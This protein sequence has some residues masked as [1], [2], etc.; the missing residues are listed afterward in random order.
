MYLQLFYG[1]TLLLFFSCTKKMEKTN[2]VI[3]NITQSVY[4]SGIIKSKNQYKVFS[5][6]NGLIAEILVAEGD[7]VKKGDALIRLTNTAAQLNVENAKIT[8]DYNAVNANSERLNELQININL[9]KAKMEE[10]D[11]LKQRQQNLWNQNIG[12]RNELEQRQ[13]A[14]KNAAT[15]YEAAKLRYAQLQKQINFQ[16]KQSQ[17]NVEISGSIRNDYLIKTNTDGKVYT[18]LMKKGEMVNTLGPVAVVGNANDFTIELQVDEYDVTEIKTGLKIVLNMDSYKGQ[19][20]EAVVTKINPILNEKTK[21]FTI[22]ASFIKQP[23]TLL[24]YLTCEANIVIQQKEK[25]ITIPRNYL[26][27]GDS[28]WI[29]PKK[30]KKAITGLKDYE[31]VEILN[32]LTAT[33]FIFKPKD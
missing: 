16:Q 24:P 29:E 28:V 5:A 30:K 31:K 13:L 12:S 6:V 4:A 20:F 19:V 1:V 15:A 25:A 26:L 2:P 10:D 7:E 17:K 21:S 9:A 27:E 11:L 23:A 18:I 22:E 32:G 14:Y 8:A 33:D 3:E